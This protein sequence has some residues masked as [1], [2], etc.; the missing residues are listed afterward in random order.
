MC[1]F[2][3]PSFCDR[4]QIHFPQSHLALPLRRVSADERRR[5]Y[6][7]RE[8]RKRHREEREKKGK[9]KKRTQDVRRRHL[10]RHFAP[11]HSLQSQTVKIHHYLPSHVWI[12]APISH[13]LLPASPFPFGSVNREEVARHGTARHGPFLFIFSLLS[14]L[15]IYL[16]ITAEG[17]NGMDKKRSGVSCPLPSLSGGGETYDHPITMVTSH[18]IQT[19]PGV[20]LPP[21]VTRGHSWQGP[22]SARARART[23]ADVEGVAADAPRQMYRRSHGEAG[24]ALQLCDDETEPNS[25]FF[26]VFFLSFFYFI[27]HTAKKKKKIQTKL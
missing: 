27:F 11:L 19:C 24:S 6:C 5:S 4:R 18:Y 2:F 21:A 9:K 14:W 1:Y 15:F 7:F 3:P 20:F 12:I 26:S 10:R 8:I 17:N 22:P 25:F 13:C 16:F 23:D